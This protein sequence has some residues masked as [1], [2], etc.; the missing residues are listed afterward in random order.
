MITLST[1]TVQPSIGDEGYPDLARRVSTGLPFGISVIILTIAL[2]IAG[3]ARAENECGRPEA[4]TPIVCSPSNYDAATDGN[5]VYRPSEAHGGE[6]KIRLTDDLSLRY[7]HRATPIDDHLFFPG[8]EG[9]RFHSAVRVETSADYEGDISLSSFAD[10][11]ST[12][13]GI[14]LS[15][16]GKSGSL[17][18]EILGGS[19]SV[20]S[21]WI[22]AFP[23][24]SYRGDL[25]ETD[26]EFSGD[27]DL[28][29]RNA[30]VNSDGAWGGIVG[31][32][33]GEGHMNIAVQNTAIK[34]DS[35]WAT[36]IGGFHVGTGD[37]DIEVE[38][39]D[40]EVRAPI[41]SSDGIYGFHSGTGDTDI[42]IRDVDIGVHSDLY[43]NG[44]SFIYRDKAA[45]KLSIDARNV[46]IEVLGERY[47]DGI[48]GM[49]DSTSTGDIDVDVRS[50][51]FVTNGA[52]SGGFSFVHDGIGDIDI[53]AID[54]DVKVH[55]DRSVGIGGGQRYRGT[56][57]IAI[58]VRDSTVAVTGESVAGIRSF[59]F[60]GEGSILV[61]VDGGSIKAEG[62]GSSGILVG[63]TGRIFGGRT[64]PIKSPAVGSVLMDE[65]EP[66]T[67]SG[68]GRVHAQNVFV[69]GRVRGGSG[70]GA[71]VRLYTG[72]QVEVG[73]QG[74]LGAASGV[75][76]R[77]EGDGAAL[78]VD[79]TLDGRQL[80]EAIEGEIRNDDGRTTVA[81]NGV[82]L[83]DGM[84]GAT[85]VWA[86]NGARD[87]SLTAAE[88]VAG[89]AFSAADFVTSLYAP[90]AAV[91]EMLP[92][93]MLRLDDRGA[94]GNR[95]RKPGSP[96]WVMVSS[97]HG[98][99]ESNQAS[100]GAAYDFGRFEAEAG[101]DFALSGE[102]DVTGWASL[103]HVRGS[104]DVSA[105]TG[106]GKI[107]ASGFG[108]SFGASWENAAG[109]HANGRILVTRLDT[110]L[111]AD[112][113]GLLKEGA[114][115]NILTL[116][117]EAGRRFS[118]ADDMSLMPQAWLTLSDV[119]MDG[120][121]D[122]VGSRVSLGQADRS[123]VGLGIVMETNPS[124]DDSDHTFA[125]RGRLGVERVVS[126]VETGMDVSDE[127]L[128]SQAARTLG[129][130]GLG[131]VQRWNRWSLS[132]EISASGL[133]TDESSY[134]A[135]LR[136][137]TQF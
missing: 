45:G 42:K 76:V 98:Q 73:P 63:L 113:R 57:D 77:A 59:N 51:T 26:Q 55:G 15:H 68:A 109:Y 116:G 19:F 36:G 82:L 128:D 136:L 7:D 127:R 41:T 48:F 37:V 28:I 20:E 133:G 83:H 52:D 93:F 131:A 78:R 40:I 27:N 112:G 102:E 44:I 103:R 71:G 61:R 130:L 58:D 43:S 123:I 107:D 75:A 126:D 88:T 99:Y 10:V 119:S 84:T 111:R 60:S 32:Q 137:G 134:A 56:G 80:S 46:D 132:G 79:L 31:F 17:R 85:G 135:S 22:R 70:I 66:D 14:S 21:D 34:V 25:H 54:V 5:I 115:A 38:D 65:I 72:G 100:V 94:V 62:T 106:G 8:S 9:T 97:G 24:H 117:V 124:R 33:G 18:T 11:T 95:L 23:I 4:G 12:G 13:R 29:V 1:S 35:Q 69:N 120:F 6:F 67:G 91:Y 50:S 49:H 3:A 16:N 96:A 114:D 47:L 110:D 90:R 121:R 2:G 101:L 104:A 108:V 39:V 129:V 92:G 53:S 86:P 64:G 87:I 74:S 105:L 89:R 81:L 125:L 30:V 122:A 118:L